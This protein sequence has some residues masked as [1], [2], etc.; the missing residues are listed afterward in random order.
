MKTLKLKSTKNSK[1]VL[2]RLNSRFELE[3][4]RISKLEVRPIDNKG[5]A[6]LVVKNP[7]VHAGNVRDVGSIPG[8]GW[9]TGG[10]HVHPLQYSTWEIPWTEEPGGL[11]SIGSKRVEEYWRD[12]AQHSL[13][14]RDK[15]VKKNEHSIRECEMPFST[16]TEARW[17]Y[18][19]KRRKPMKQK[20]NIQ[21]NNSWKVLN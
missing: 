13:K 5:Q 15:R 14:T 8:L 21:G 3:E 2:E 16:P 17:V 18:Q 6:V 10:G 12:L 11:Q 1:N 4:K 9:S 20:K 7:P 19:N